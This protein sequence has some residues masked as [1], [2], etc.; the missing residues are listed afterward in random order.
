MPVLKPWLVMFLEPKLAFATTWTEPGEE[1]IVSDTRYKA[2]YPGS[3]VSF[4]DRILDDSGRFAGVRFCP[5]SEH[6]KFL[7]GRLP[8]RSYLRVTAGASCFDVYFRGPPYPKGSSEGDQAFGGR[9]YEA[10]P[11]QLAISLDLQ[12]LADSAD[13]LEAVRTAA[14]HWIAL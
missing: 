9:L 5:T 4:Y 11:G 3:V 1:F 2:I 12:Y 6:L 13:D 7:F 14:V 8:A 10:E